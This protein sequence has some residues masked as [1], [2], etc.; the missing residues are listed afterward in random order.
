MDGLRKNRKMLSFCLLTDT[1]YT[2]NGT[3]D[4]TAAGVAKLTRN[5][6]VDAII[7]LG[8]FTDGLE[9]KDVTRGYV[10]KILSDL[11]ANRLPVYVTIG[12]HDY[13]FYKGNRERFSK[14]EVLECLELEKEYYYQDFDEYKIRCLFLHSYDADTPVRYGFSDEEVDWIEETIYAAPRG[15]KVL[16]FSHGAPLYFLD[17]WSRIIR[18]SEKLMDILETYNAQ[19]NRQILAFIHGHTHAEHVYRGSSFPI[20]SIGCNKCEQLVGKIPVGSYAYERTRGTDTQDLWDVL[21]IDTESEK[22][23]FERMGAGEDRTVDCRKSG[24]T[25]RQDE[26][27]KKQARTTKIWAHRGSS[28]FAPENTLPAFKIAKELNVDGIELDV[29]M[30]KD[31]ELVV[32]HDESIDRTSDG[33]GWVKD[34][35]LA[36]LR[37]FNFNNG[38]NGFGF[39]E[40]PTLREVYEMFQ[41]TDYV[42]NVE[43]KTGVIAYDGIEKKVHELT[44]EM[45]MEKQVIYSSFSHTSVLKMQQFVTEEK[46]AFLFSDGWLDVVEYG[47]KYGVNALHPALYYQGLKEMVKEAHD[48]GMKVH[49]WTVNEEEHALMLRDMGVDAI[50]TNHPGKMREL[51]A[52]E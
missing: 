38:K 44:V 51:Y 3:W 30:T 18:N 36:E 5:T 37:T 19:E 33:S 31:G 17:Y 22:L 7:H 49:V 16:I 39:V 14:E 34:F 46:T 28:G 24:S 50:I 6:D 2:E 23:C 52:K 11:K 25:W 41:G 47:K 15:Y 40:I 26:A 20:I 48:K 1:H 42:I 4:D 12:N 9:S 45:G 13:N 32:I 43:L 35:T 10:E 8:D 29:Q 21:R 27:A